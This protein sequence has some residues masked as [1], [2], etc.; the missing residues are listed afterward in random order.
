MTTMIKATEQLSLDKSFKIILSTTNLP[1]INQSKCI[2]KNL[3]RTLVYQQLSTKAADTIYQRFLH[4]VDS[5]E[6]TPKQ[7]LKHSAEAM[8]SVGLSRQ[9]AHYILNTAHYFVDK[10]TKLEAW[11]K[12]SLDELHEKL[13]V[14]KGVGPWTVNMISIF[15]LEHQDTFPINDLTIK[16]TIIELYG[17]DKSDKNVNKKILEIAEK[18]RP[19]RSVASRYLWAWKDQQ[20]QIES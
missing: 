2:F 15:S 3:V 18:W 10:P 9:K 5:Q 6:Y 12:L 13:I 16:N 19:F 14:I 1:K 20:K 4:L 11:K 17:L 7:V 8:R